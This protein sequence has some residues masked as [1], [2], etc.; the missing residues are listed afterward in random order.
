MTK[1]EQQTVVGVFTDRRHAEGAMDA[2]RHA[3]FAEHDI[4]FLSPTGGGTAEDTPTAQI[5]HKA[6]DGAVKG[7]VT[8]GAVGAVAGGVAM[9]AGL[10]PGIGPVIAGGILLGILGGGAAG[11]AL[12][13]Y[14]G[15]FLGMS[16]VDDRLAHHVEREIAGG[17]TVVT[18]SAGD[19]TM[20]AMDILR[21]HGAVSVHGPGAEVSEDVV[22][23]V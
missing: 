8:G 2:L 21:D 23:P 13:T 5:E 16:N 20:K 12:G 22:Q 9:A 18:V 11:A 4:G 14:L 17:R 6:E 15:P 1:T 10:I 19:R 7:A 3:L